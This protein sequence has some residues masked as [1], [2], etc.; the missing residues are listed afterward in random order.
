M[1]GDKP[2]AADL[3]RT[4]EICKVNLEDELP[5]C[6]YCTIGE[7]SLWERLEQIQISPD[8]RTV[9]SILTGWSEQIP[10][11]NLQQ[12]LEMLTKPS[13]RRFPRS[14]QPK[15]APFVV[16]EGIDSSGKTTHVEAIAAALAQLH[17]SVRIITFP[18]NLTPLGR[19]LKHILQKGSQLETWTQHILFS[20]H[21]WEMLDLIQESLLTGTAV[22]CERY[23]WSGVVY[24]YVG[25]P[26]MPLQ[27]Y[28]T[29][30]QGILQPDVVILLT[31]SPQESMGRRNAISPQFEDEGIQQKLWD[32]FHQDCLWEG[33]TRM[34]Y[35]PL[36]RPHES[37]KVLQVKLVN[38]LKTQEDLD[39]W[40]YLWEISKPC[41]VCHML[42]NLE[43]PIQTCTVCYRQV[44]HVCLHSDDQA[45]SIPVCRA[46]AS[47]PDPD[48]TE[49]EV[50]EAPDP[51][52]GEP[53]K[54]VVEEIPSKTPFLDATGVVPC[55]HH[56]MDHLTRDPS[57]EYCKKALGPLYRHLKG[58]YGI[59]LD[60]QTPTLSFDFSG[61]FPVSATGAR[62]MLL[63]VW[64]LLDIRLLW[65]FALD[66]RTKENVRSC[67]QDVLAELTQMTGGSKPPVMRVHSDQ[68]GE[69]LSPVVMEWLKQHNIKQTFT[70]GHDPAANGVAERWID[71]V[72][73]KA[74]VLLAANH[75]STA[76]WNYAVAWVTYAYNNKVLATPSKKALPEFGQLILV[77]SNRDHKLQDKGDLAIMMGIYP[78]ISNGIV[79]LRVKDGKL[80]ELCTAHCSN[81]HVEK[82]LQWFLKRD[83]N[84]PTR[85]IYVSNKGEA[86]WDIP[87]S[88]LPTVEEKE[89]WNRH[90]TFASLQRSRDGWAW[91]TANI[92]RLLPSYKD[93]EVED[94]EDPLPYLGDAGFFTYTQLPQIEADASHDN[95]P[96][97]E[98]PFVPRS[99]LDDDFQPELPPPPARGPRYIQGDIRLPPRVSDEL[100][101]LEE[102]KQRKESGM[103]DQEEHPD[104]ELEG[105]I[106]RTQPEEGLSSTMVEERTPIPQIG[107]GG[108]T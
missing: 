96:P 103:T 41:R 62:F 16:I 72:K 36:L 75:L 56:G 69:F 90:P 53:R 2:E 7:G 32:T 50:A 1:L 99:M 19:F 12:G 70:S 37:R 63:F 31:T 88:S 104:Q 38:L 9:M 34:D 33:V 59:R 15:G 54:E 71:L 27:A 17:Y 52:D 83:P 107:G 93:I 74:T 87:I 68:A 102:E 45:A 51:P 18:N 94:V 22:I 44:H 98:I 106:N 3:G 80:G 47:D 49:M 105:E 39:Q 67:L 23:V 57:C 92:G 76:Y 58:K 86:V 14:T 46:C 85:R 28:M 66:R 91:Y 20:L 5:W 10:R 55:P 6:G 64:R 43:Q 35:H 78:R 21:R 84:N 25:N 30:D 42:T 100:T 108:G 26:G 8:E 40:K 4:C 60:D 82:D 97:M 24:S 73:I 89:V 11:W 81:T 95:D 61:P 48:K 29:C 77:R 101:R 65:A 13:N 79:A